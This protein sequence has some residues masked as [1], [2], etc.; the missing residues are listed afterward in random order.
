[1]SQG[2]LYALA[3]VALVTIGLHAMIVKAGFLRRIL[4]YNV[5]GSGIFLMLVALSRR[6]GEAP[7][8]PIPQAMVITGIVVAIAATALALALLLKQQALARE[9][10]KSRERDPVQQ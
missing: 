1:M 7:P 2:V 5:C 9:E 3:G 6:N 10:S 8:D 4:A